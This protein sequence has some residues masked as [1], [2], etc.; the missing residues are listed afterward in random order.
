MFYAKGKCERTIEGDN[1]VYSG[2]CVRCGKGQQA[3]VKLDNVY[4]WE[5]GSLI[6][7]AF[8]YLDA[9]EREFLISGICPV[10]FDNLG[11]N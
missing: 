9:G 11:V 4:E 8:P 2:P 10:C 3:V 7:D 6:Q 5:Q 1:V